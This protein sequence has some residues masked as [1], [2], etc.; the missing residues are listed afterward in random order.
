MLK[1]VQPL[2]TDMKRSVSSGVVLKEVT[3]RMVCPASLSPGMGHL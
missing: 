3:R 2:N 1:A